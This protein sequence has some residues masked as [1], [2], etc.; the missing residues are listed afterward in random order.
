MS[1]IV[2]RTNGS[3]FQMYRDADIYGRGKWEGNDCPW[4]HLPE[5][6]QTKMEAQ[7]VADRSKTAEPDWMYEVS[8]Y[9]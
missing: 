8:Y 6:Y 4:W 9:E 3:V 1:Y 2:T 7:A 5:Q